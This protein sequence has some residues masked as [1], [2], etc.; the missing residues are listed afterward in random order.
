MKRKNL[1]IALVVL[2]SACSR[3]PSSL[4]EHIQQI[5]LTPL[6]A[7]SSVSLKDESGKITIVNF[8]ATWCHQCQEELIALNR[9]YQQFRGTG[10][11]VLAIPVEDTKA[12]VGDFASNAALSLPIL[13]DEER[14]LT[15]QFE[16][17]S[18]P[19]TLVWDC[20]G[21]LTELVSTEL[22]REKHP[23]FRRMTWEGIQGKEYIEELLQDPACAD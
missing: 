23:E 15:G 2:L 8:F 7:P 6:G 18:L 13:F 4:P 19:H 3:R 10:V 11:R 14:K 16:T 5:A 21:S 9:L 1:T 20:R 22:Q 17:S 12:R